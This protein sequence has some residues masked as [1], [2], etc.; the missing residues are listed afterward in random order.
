MESIPLAETSNDLSD[1]E[2]QEITDP[3]FEEA[4]IDLGSE[5]S[6]QMQDETIEPAITVD[7]HML[8]DAKRTSEE[9][10]ED[11]ENEVEEQ[12]LRLSLSPDA[13]VYESRLLGLNGMTASLLAQTVLISASANEIILATNPHT[14]S[15]INDMHQWRITKAFASQLGHSAV[16][17]VEVRDDLAET[18][19]QH[20]LRLSQERLVLAKNSLLKIHL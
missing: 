12:S 15:L 19:E 9:Q 6:R 7:T 14:H 5:S 8:A 1:T 3:V 17:V 4:I 16:L 18:P 13:W 11:T 20:R 10:A 2:H